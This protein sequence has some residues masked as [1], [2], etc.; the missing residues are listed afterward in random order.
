[1]DDDRKAALDAAHALL[2]EGMGFAAGALPALLARGGRGRGR[3]PK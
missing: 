1:M 3:G 2:A